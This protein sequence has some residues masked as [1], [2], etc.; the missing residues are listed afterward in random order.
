MT[1]QLSTT[2]LGQQ[3]NEK[4]HMSRTF[5]WVYIAFHEQTQK[6]INNKKGTS[7]VDIP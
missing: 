1:A 5:G 7:N 6:K 4:L 3:A 2:E